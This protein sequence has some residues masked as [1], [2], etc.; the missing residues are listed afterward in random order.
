M[1]YTLTPATLTRAQMHGEA[2]LPCGSI[3]VAQ[4]MVD[5]GSW[6]Y[7]VV[8]PASDLCEKIAYA[9]PGL[10]AARAAINAPEEEA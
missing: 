6:K 3:L 10:D 2:V 7:A 1:T 5:D 4:P 9:R 8:W